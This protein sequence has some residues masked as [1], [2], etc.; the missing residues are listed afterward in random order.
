MELEMRES[1]SEI[2][3]MEEKSAIPLLTNIKT[4]ATSETAS[5][6]K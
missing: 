5:L 1:I 4:V 3:V 6:Q 2:K